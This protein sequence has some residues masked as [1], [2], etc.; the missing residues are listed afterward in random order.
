M[1]YLLDTHVA[2]WFFAGDERLSAPARAAI[3]DPSAEINISIASAW[4][5]AIK[6]SLQKL[7]F[8][9]G[10]LAFFDMIDDNGF[11]LLPLTKTHLDGLARLPFHHRDPFDRLLAAAALAESMRLIS[12][13]AALRHYGASLVW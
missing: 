12:A 11:I 7:Q 6:M 8:E 1:R 4:E 13:D 10:V 5:M 9:G 2:L 3:L